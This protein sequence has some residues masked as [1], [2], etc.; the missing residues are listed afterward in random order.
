MGDARNEFIKGEFNK[1][2]VSDKLTVD[3]TNGIDV[4]YLLILHFSQ[5]VKM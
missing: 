5:E 1:C 4:Q 3:F 2:T